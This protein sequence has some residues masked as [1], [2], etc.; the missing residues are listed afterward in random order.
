M[1]VAAKIKVHLWDQ[2]I[3]IGF[4]LALF[5][6]L[7]S[8]LLYIF[9]SYDVNFFNRLLG[10]GISEVWNRL[11]ILCL[12]II[13][14]SHAQ[15]TINKRKMAEG[16][17]RESEERFRTIIE[18]TPDGY[19]EVDL[20]GRFTFINDSM[21][22]IL[23][24]S[25][26]E[27]TG[28][29]HRQSLDEA[30]AKK[31]I[32]I[33]NNIFESGEAVKNVGW[34]TVK[35][36]GAKRFVEGSLS[37]LKDPR[38]EPSGFGGF[39]R[40]VTE[41]KHA[42]ALY[43]AKLEA[44]AANRTKSEFLA[45]MSH[46][47]RTPLNA[48][49]GLV[50]L[51]LYTDLRPE[52]REDL[53]VVRASAYSLLSIINNILDFSKIE[54]G[55]L[56]MEDSTFGLREFIDESMKIMAMKSHEKNIELAYRIDPDVPNQLIGDPTRFRQVLL[57]LV[58]NAVKFTSTGE[59]LVSISNKEQTAEEAYISISVSDTGIGIPADSQKS[60][61]G[62]YD[63]GN[64]GTSGRYGGTGLG[65]A[66]T[67]QLVRLM[68]GNIRVE[69]NPGQGSRFYFTARFTRPQGAEPEIE[70]AADPVLQ[71]INVLVAD[72]NAASREILKTT[73]ESWQMKPV[74]AASAQE[75]QQMLS[76]A[77]SEGSPI[78]L[79]L[80][81]SDMPGKDGFELAKWIKEQGQFDGK[82]LM[83]L[84]FPH[85]KRKSDFEDLDIAAG[86]LKPVQVSELRR[87]ILSSLEIQPTEPEE[88]RNLAEQG[89]PV[90]S[91][92]LKILVV[93][94]TPFNQKFILRLLERWNHPAVLVD[95]GR[96]ALEALAKEDFD[97]VLMDVQM[98][99]MDGLETTAA[100]RAEE[101]KTGR[102][103]PI[104]AMTAHA[105]KGDR[106][107]CL[108]A[109][110]DEYVSKPIASA[111]LFQTIEA[112]TA[113]DVPVKETSDD[114][115]PV[116]AELNKASL[117]G[118]FD[119]DWDF[120]KEIVDIF[121]S[122]YPK[123][124]DDLRAASREGDTAT[125]MR[126]AHTI[127]GMLRNFQLEDAAEIAFDLEKKGNAGEITAVDSAID[128]LADQLHGLEKALKDMLEN[129]NA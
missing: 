41:R 69:S 91:R 129:R 37:L 56:E 47:I 28:M 18:T 42:E 10:P 97:I 123:L 30:S 35:K 98:P 27:I 83:L 105:I 121:I 20:G 23:G 96:K 36:D 65:L 43:R 54:A 33:F 11:A 40:D 113:G 107:R 114:A 19:Y 94:D 102:H 99:E 63:Q 67:A 53:D 6:Y 106:E 48:I 101:E 12:F 31:L 80:I 92:Q 52:Q 29:N 64:A 3:I 62:A 86:V 108:E 110:M 51:M 104:I 46:E 8:S 45:H 82:T 66:V 1:S 13:F 95:N 128:T 38:G 117:L 2:M 39:L 14:G 72:D 61:F 75:A 7:F 58:D 77:K 81:D 9:L 22:G 73:L 85:L 126:T 76:K 122:D 16:A 21:C 49:I 32:E 127:K 25:L 15:Y 26:E 120:F 100:I 112:L 124:L 115:D 125:F 50:E 24:Y 17:L 34:T 88:A 79:I 109:G 87:A 78:G 84:T 111:K 119:H 59:V 118:A 93:E 70:A 68:G 44:E 4:G 103:I 116:A 5:Y 90:P 89:P 55:K 60:I 57:N 74:L 71:D